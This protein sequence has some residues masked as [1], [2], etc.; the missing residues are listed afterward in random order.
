MFSL[1]A[2]E[3]GDCFLLIGM[4]QKGDGALIIFSAVE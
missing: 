3:K 4:P 2:K 1:T